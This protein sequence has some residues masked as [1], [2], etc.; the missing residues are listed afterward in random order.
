MPV[1]LS[2]T[3]VLRR[4][5]AVSLAYALAGGFLA[6]VYPVFLRSRGLNQLEINSVLAAY[7]IVSLL[8]DVPTG[9]FAD[10]LGRRVSFVA[11]CA[12]RGLAF[13]LYFVSHTYGLFLV[14][15]TIDA[16]GTTFC[17]GAVDAW[18]VDALDEAGF[19][20]T[21]DHLFSRV[22]Q[23]SS[24]GMM[25]TAVIGALVAS[26][27]IAWPWLL[28]A[29]GFAVSGFMGALLRER[30]VGSARL[31]LRV[32]LRAVAARLR[33]GIHR[34]VQ[35]RAVRLL[36]VA[37]G[38]MLAIW[39]PYWVEWPLLFGDA[40]GVGVWVVGWIFCVQGLAYMIGAE[41]VVRAGVLA[42]RRPA[43]LAMLVLA[44]GGLMIVAGVLAENPQQAL[45]A[46]VLMNV[47]GGAREPLARSWFNEEVTPDERATLLSFRSAVA[48]AGGS[49]GLLL[50]GYVVDV[51]GIPF[52][53]R[54]AGTLALLAAPC[55]WA[56]RR[57]D[58]S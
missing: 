51:R 54:M 53:W 4:Y 33:A 38:I 10:A 52:H 31:E 42:T 49:L 28:G 3:S 15:E 46:L 1:T 35:L 8:T 26:V 56:L 20:K 19:A 58:A 47:A 11:G 50:G 39:A 27:D 30:V 25:T 55:Y 36:S 32:V 41:V 5:Y 43:A 9:A 16:V 22:T 29:A 37:E 45:V 34:G 13:A 57:R 40:F 6:G 12:L 14:A 21:K 17:N 2:T 7:F 44:I 23:L 24:L 18:G 48:T